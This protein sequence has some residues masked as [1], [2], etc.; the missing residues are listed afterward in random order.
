MIQKAYRSYKGRKR[1][2]EQDREKQAAIVIQNCYRRYKQVSSE[3][4]QEARYKQ[5]S[6]ELLP[7]V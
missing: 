5:M 3:L 1:A 7:E 4:L 2:E 6:S